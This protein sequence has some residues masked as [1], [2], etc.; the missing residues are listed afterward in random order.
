M[1]FNQVVSLPL[2]AEAFVFHHFSFLTS[3]EF[4]QFIAAPHGD[5]AGKCHGVLQLT[6]EAANC[7]QW[8]KR[9]R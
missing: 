4:A 3:L 8:Q 7:G 1:P 5:S 6:T 2:L 9:S